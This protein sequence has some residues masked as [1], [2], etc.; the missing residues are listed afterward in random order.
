M[1]RVACLLLL[2]SSA[3][4]GPSIATESSTTPA[5]AK[6]VPGKPEPLASTRIEGLGRFDRVSR[7]EANILCGL[8]RGHSPVCVNDALDASGTNVPSSASRAA[9]YEALDD[10]VDLQAQM[11]GRCV[12][13]GNETLRCDF[14]SP[15]A[16]LPTIANPAEWPIIRTD[17]T[18]FV[19]SSITSESRVYAI[20]NERRLHVTK[21][22]SD[23]TKLASSQV[24][25]DVVSVRWRDWS[26]AC[27]LRRNGDVMCSDPNAPDFEMVS[28]GIH[29]G[30]A[31]HNYGA[32]ITRNN[33]F[34]YVVDSWHSFDPWPKVA[35]DYEFQSG[36]VIA[37]RDG[38][39]T[40]ANTGGVWVG[41]TLPAKPKRFAPSGDVSCALLVDDTTACW[42]PWLDQVRRLGSREAPPRRPPLELAK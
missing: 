13:F 8:R 40:C 28:T 27:A 3:V 32:V 30:R 16:A 11:P 21:L 29:D 1:R 38:A 20:D 10:V 42:L 14:T 15:L 2:S 7:M 25:T 31:L 4:A 37:P 23:P 12:L 26:G 24:A 5:V 34:T 35:R 36:C 19:I 18:G 22:V 17:V 39:V 41:V 6:T 9:A 33:A